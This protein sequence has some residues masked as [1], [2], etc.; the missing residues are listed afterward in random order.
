M[1]DDDRDDDDAAAWLHKLSWSFGQISQKVG[2][3]KGFSTIMI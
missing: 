1:P 2:V 3:I